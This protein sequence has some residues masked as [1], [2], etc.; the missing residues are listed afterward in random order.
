MKLA[1]AAELVKQDVAEIN[2]DLH[3]TPYSGIDT[4]GAVAN[5]PVNRFF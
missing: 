3:R 4:G 5:D 2:K 1:Q